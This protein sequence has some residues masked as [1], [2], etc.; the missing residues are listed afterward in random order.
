MQATKVHN[1]FIINLLHKPNDMLTI[2][3]TLQF[4]TAVLFSC[5]LHS[6]KHLALCVWVFVYVLAGRT[7]FGQKLTEP[8]NG[9]FQLCLRK[10]VRSWITALQLATYWTDAKK[11]F[12]TKMGKEKK[13]KNNRYCKTLCVNTQ[14]QNIAKIFKN[15]C[16]LTTF[17]QPEHCLKHF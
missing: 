5:S 9:N 10:Q 13:K 15:I 8:A 14:A 17:I 11:T 7:L 4:H 2:D 1:K 3:C 16:I 12:A 6:C